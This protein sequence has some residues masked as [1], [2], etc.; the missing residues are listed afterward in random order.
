MNLGPCLGLPL[1]APVVGAAPP[2]PNPNLLLWTEEF[3]NAAWTKTT[4]SV[5]ANDTAGPLSGSTADRIDYQAPFGTATQ[6]TTTAAAAGAEVHLDI[7]DV[8]TT[9]TRYEISGTFSAVVYVFSVY[10]K[11]T[12][13][14]IGGRI[15][16]QRSGGFLACSVEDIGDVGSCWACCAQ[17][18]VGATATVYVRRG[19]S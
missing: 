18:E 12:E 9:W 17:L 16:L 15:R 5:V 19:G 7:F 4:A 11:Q 2:A 6:A 13:A 3:D 14:G 8:A 10:L 1:G